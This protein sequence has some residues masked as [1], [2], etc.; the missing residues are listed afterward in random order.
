[1][2]KENI[3]NFYG[4]NYKIV[5]PVVKGIFAF[6]MLW[7]INDRI[8]YMSRIDNILVMLVLAV[9]CAVTP[10]IVSVFVGLGTVLAHLSSLSV[11]LTA[12]ALALF[13]VMLLLYLRFCTRDL[14]MIILVP[15]T[16]YFKIPYV[17]PL[18]LGVVSVPSSILTMCC[19]I[20]VHYY[21]DYISVNAVTIQ[22][23]AATG[24]LE[25][26]RVGIDA[27]IHNEE[28]FLTIAIFAITSMV[29]YLIRRLSI[30]YARSVAIFAGALVNVVLSFM[31]LLVFESGPS[32][33]GLILGTI[34][35]IP[36]AL[37]I[38][39]FNIGVDYSRT[40]RVQFEDDDYYYYVKAV[41]KMNIQAPAKTVKK[42]N[43]QRRH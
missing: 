28:M 18:V 27:F 38:S 5:K 20:I 43:P 11:E 10:S 41:P 21:I 17:L 16:F 25:K 3:K 33:L 39:F 42:I 1:M 23:M 37:I 35:S 36:I 26:I 9:V 34:L 7:A 31:G 2:I 19:G 13:A 8:G 4:S 14:F 12:I 29:V 22:G 32:V 30:D 24:T 40:E 15:L 6:L